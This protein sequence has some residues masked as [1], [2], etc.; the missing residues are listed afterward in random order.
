MTTSTKSPVSVFATNAYFDLDA[1]LQRC[2]DDAEFLAEMIDLLSTSV[3]T[4][5]HT[6]VEAIRR[7]DP[8][9]IAVSAHA[10]KG[11]V[12][13]MTTSVPY[14]LAWE[15]EQLGKSGDCTGAEPLFAA[16]QISLDRLLCETGDW[17]AQ[18]RLATTC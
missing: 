16:L 7:R 10:L 2:C 18:H 11:T 12:A 3:V 1:A 15:L 5:G 8:H 9:A 6:I 14:Q 17:V 13:S 4:Q